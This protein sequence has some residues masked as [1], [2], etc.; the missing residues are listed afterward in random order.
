MQSTLRQRLMASTLFIGACVLATPAWAQSPG[1]DGEPQT[2]PIEGTDPA[3]DAQ[4]NPI[5]GSDYILVT[6]SRIARGPNIENTVPTLVVGQEMFQA[7]EAVNFADVATQLPQFAASFGASRTQSTFSGTATSGLQ[8]VNLRNLGGGRTLTLLNGRRMPGGTTTGTAVDFNTIPSVNI[9][10]VE[11]I[12]GGASAIYGAD[13][14]AGVVNIITR[15]NFEGLEAGASYRITQRGDDATPMG[16]MLFG[17]GIGDGGH[18]LATVQV[19]RQ[20]EVEC[21]DRYLCA[22]DF[23]WAPPADP[24]RSPTA[25]S[26][27]GL[28]GRFFVPAGNGNPAFDVT[29]AGAT[30]GEIFSTAIHGYNRNADRTLAQETDRFLVAFEGS[31]PIMQGVNLFAEANYGLSRTDAQFEGHPF[32]S[33]QAGSLFG[34]G[35]GVPGLQAS[36]PID[37]PFIPDFLR[38]AVLTNSPTA[39]SITWWDRFQNLAARGAENE[40]Q[41]FRMVGGVRGDFDLGLGSNWNYEVHYVYGQT[42]LDAQTRGLVSTRNLYYGL[43]VEAD[44][45]NPGQFRCADAGARASGCVPINPFDG[46]NQAERDALNVSAGLRGRSEITDLQAFVSG[47][48]MRLPGGDLSVAF[49]VERRTFSGFLDYDEE[50]NNAQVTGNQIGDVDLV[51][52]QTK[53]AYVEGVAPILG[54]LPFLQSLTLEGAYRWSDPSVGSSYD[55]WRYGG[56]AEFIPGVRVRAMRA[57]AVRE[58]TP[59]ELSGVGQTFG[60]VTDPC[61]DEAGSKRQSN[62]TVAANCLAAGVPVGYSPPQTIRQGTGGFVGGNPNLEPE[63]ATTLTYGIAIAPPRSG[64][65]GFL[66]GFALTVDRFEIEIDDVIQTVGRQVKIDKCYEEG[67]FCGDIVRGPHPL[68]PGNAAL[69][70]V[71]DQLINLA[72]ISLS[73]W[74]IEARYSFGLPFANSRLTL[75]GVV[76]IYDKA[77]VVNLP[78]DEPE[79]FLDFAGGSTSEQGWI[80]IT[81]VGNITYQQAGT[82]LN[83][84]IRYIGEA[85]TANFAPDTYPRIGDRWYHNVRVSQAVGENFEFYVGVNNIADSAPPFFPSG[86]AGTQALDTVPA[87]Y[88]IFGRTFY[89]G[90][91]LT[92]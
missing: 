27:V 91:R 65:L 20:G 44:P 7:T 11:V 41:M 47:P 75:Q 31:Y 78:G 58:P 68:V 52:R 14:V 32:Q 6:G 59:G 76:T 92:F 56:S 19:T 82:T 46:Y 25:R 50:I 62:A 54:D 21:N 30:T 12:T 4:G 8:L 55:T 88:D 64:P 67:L 15:S 48:L 84:N 13:A 3:V 37:N 23:F 5:T 35:P 72:E 81:G 28:F 85:G 45:A 86:T 73:G 71:N 79:D 89:S 51:R 1:L 69:I 70:G 16:Y 29:R 36:I 18:I 38:N 17:S 24:N 77:E 42:T 22:E 74:D 2:G 57:R 87:Y 40:R 61:I 43:R 26:G 39:T 66:N 34:G 90:V 83:W 80:D 63:R 49:G 33:N 60:V 53:E 10:R 9:A